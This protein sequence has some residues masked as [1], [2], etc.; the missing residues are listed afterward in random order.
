[1]IRGCNICNTV[2]FPSIVIYVSSNGKPFLPSVMC[3]CTFN[4]LFNVTIIRGISVY[5]QDVFI[6]SPL[7]SDWLERNTLGSLIYTSM[8]PIHY[9]FNG[10]STPLSPS[11]KSGVPYRIYSYIENILLFFHYHIFLLP[12]LIGFSLPTSPTVLVPKHSGSYRIIQN[13]LGDCRVICFIPY[14]YII[15]TRNFSLLL[16]YTR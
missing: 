5:L 3:L 2:F 9:K 14:T 16:H 7:S 13:H 1:M 15:I 10:F 11:S 6:N 12:F 8:T 4:Y